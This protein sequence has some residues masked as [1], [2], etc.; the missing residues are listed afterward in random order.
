MTSDPE[1]S[2]AVAQ[3]VFSEARRFY[4][5]TGH[6]PAQVTV[7]GPGGTAN[8]LACVVLV[9]ADEVTCTSVQYDAQFLLSAV[10]AKPP[11]G[12]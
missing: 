6:L 8:H 11:S 4:Q 1:G 10:G 2:C 7:A 9:P 5:Q 3:A 12:Y